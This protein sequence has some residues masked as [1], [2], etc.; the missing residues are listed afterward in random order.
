MSSKSQE[1]DGESCVG[2]ES[3]FPASAMNDP[4]LQILKKRKR[5]KD[6]IDRGKTVYFKV[7]M[8]GNNSS[9]NFGE[10]VSILK[11]YAKWFVIFQQV[12]GEND[13]FKSTPPP[14]SSTPNKK[15]KKKKLFMED[16]SSEEE[17]EKEKSINNFFCYF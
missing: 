9:K 11:K 4:A 6:I 8:M 2:E 12:L 1:C 14:K 17:E 16:T 13:F 10:L 7:R 3:S 15:P 5:K